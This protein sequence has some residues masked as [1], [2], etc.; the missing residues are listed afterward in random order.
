VQI[1]RVEARVQQ[2]RDGNLRVGRADKKRKGREKIPAS[3]ADE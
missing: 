1:L 3:L 2:I